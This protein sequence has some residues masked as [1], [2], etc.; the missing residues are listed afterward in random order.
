MYLDVIVKSPKSM[1]HDATS[2]PIVIVSEFTFF[3]D[4]YAYT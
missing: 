3:K 4:E 1:L 2:M